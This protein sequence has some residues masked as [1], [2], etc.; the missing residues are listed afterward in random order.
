MKIKNLLYLLLVISF[1]NCSY[2][3]E[4]DLTENLSEDLVNYEDNIKTIIDNNCIACHNNPPVNGAPMSLTTYSNV[5]DA[6]ENRSLI[7]RISSTDL[8]FS[9][10]FGGPRLPQNLID[11]LLLW[12]AEGLIEN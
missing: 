1:Y 3:N 10:P 4:D 11:L 9:M 12:E 6:I 5:K 8:G 2:V 7:N